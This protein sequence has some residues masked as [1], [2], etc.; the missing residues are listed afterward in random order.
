MHNDRAL[1]GGSESLDPPDKLEQGRGVVGD[2]VVRPGR[3]LELMNFARLPRLN[4][5]QNQHWVK[6]SY[7][8]FVLGN[9]KAKFYFYNVDNTLN[10]EYD[11]KHQIKKSIKLLKK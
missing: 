3:E 6:I 8:I 9:L 4:L 10:A 2:S 11:V 5:N 7:K 1:V